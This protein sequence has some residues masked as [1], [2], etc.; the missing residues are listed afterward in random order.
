MTPATSYYGSK[1]YQK[2]NGIL[3]VETY[4]DLS[5]IVN[6]LES[7]VDYPKGK[8][9]PYVKS[10]IDRYLERYGYNP[11]YGERMKIYDSMGVAKGYRY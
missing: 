8:R 7:N 4:A 10:L 9:S 1:D 6:G 3:P 11:T 2:V 5:S